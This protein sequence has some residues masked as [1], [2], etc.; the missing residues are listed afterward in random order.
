MGWFNA[1]LEFVHYVTVVVGPGVEGY[2]AGELNM[3]CDH[4]LRQ[5]SLRWF[6]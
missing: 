4:I 2:K 1:S 5:I 3:F 6:V